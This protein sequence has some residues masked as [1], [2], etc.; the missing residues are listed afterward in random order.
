M[1]SATEAILR[2]AHLGGECAESLR[3]RGGPEARLARHHTKPVAERA[4]DLPAHVGEGLLGRQP[5]A[6]CHGEQVEDGRQL[7]EDRLAATGDASLQQ[8]VR[9]EEAHDE[10]EQPDPDR[11][12]TERM[13]AREV[14]GREERE[15]EKPNG[16]LLAEELRRRRTGPAVVSAVQGRPRRRQPSTVTA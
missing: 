10:P 4:A 8:P 12:R 15:E 11:P 2:D 5:G 3:V 6:C 7:D 13:Q 14:H 16:Q 1:A 9:L